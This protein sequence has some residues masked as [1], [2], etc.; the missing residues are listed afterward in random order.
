MYLKFLWIKNDILPGGGPRMAGAYPP[1][2]GPLIE[3][4][5]GGFIRGFIMPGG[6]PNEV[7]EKNE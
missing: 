3:G 7:N 5:R 4:P 1:G 6:P 2:I